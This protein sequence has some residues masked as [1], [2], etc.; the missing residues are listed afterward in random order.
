[1]ATCRRRAS[2]R[3]VRS[4]RGRS[5]P[6]REHE[7]PPLRINDANGAGHLVR[8]VPA[9]LDLDLRHEPTVAPT[10]IYTRATVGLRICFVTPFAWSQP[11]DVNEHVDGVAAALRRLGH[12]VTVLA[13]STRARDLLAGRR[14]LERGASAELDRDRPV[15]ARSRAGRAWASRSACARTSGSRSRSGRFDVVHGFEPGLPS[16][17][18]L[19][20]A[21]AD[22]LTVATFLSP[23]RLG[24]PPGA[25]SRET[26]LGR[27][28]ALLATSEDDRGAP[29]PSGSRATTGSSRSASTP[30]SSSRR[31]SGSSSRSSSSPAAAGYARA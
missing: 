5:S 17:S 9:H 2:S 10:D 12:D 16:L 19:A 29:L 27:I 7:L 26:L 15:G 25:R 21:T 20:L 13:P 11:H 31:R 4:G 22:A 3:S 24:Y 1:M 6:L 30:S 18:Y 14:A 28:D 8:A 23:E